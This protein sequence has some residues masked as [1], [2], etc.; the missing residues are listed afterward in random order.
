MR[1][2]ML[3]FFLFPDFVVSFYMTKP[4]NTSNKMS[5]FLKNIF[6]HFYNH[7]NE[8]RFP[9]NGKGEFVPGL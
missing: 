4:R 1:K 2:V 3:S 8:K 7:G 9:T 5:F 6:V